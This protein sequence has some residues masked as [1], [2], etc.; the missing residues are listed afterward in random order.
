MV[1]RQP[2]TAALG[3]A[4][5]ASLTLSVG[6]TACSGG[7]GSTASPPAATAATTPPATTTTPGGGSATLTVP[8][9]VVTYT[10]GLPGGAATSEGK[11]HVVWADPGYLYVV[12]Y[13]SSTCPKF[14]SSVEKTE[15]GGIRITTSTD[16]SRPCTMDFGPTTSTVEVPDGVVDTAPVAVALDGVSSTLPAR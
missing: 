1:R 2:R 10:R 6:L 14:P 4:A 12:T 11:D 5:L 7:N 13:G 15:S 8:T 9:P 3:L 16:T